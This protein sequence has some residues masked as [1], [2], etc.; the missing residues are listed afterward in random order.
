[1]P[2]MPR[3]LDPN[4]D[5]K[6]AE[7]TMRNRIAAAKSKAKKREENELM[8]ARND[9]LEECTAA[10]ARRCDSIWEQSSELE[11]TLEQMMQRIAALRAE[12][13]ALTREKAAL[14]VRAP[15]LASTAP[16]PL[17]RP[18]V[19]LLPV[20]HSIF[21]RPSSWA[22]LVQ[23]GSPPRGSVLARVAIRCERNTYTWGVDAPC[24]PVLPLNGA[25]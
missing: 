12:K 24:R 18:P 25:P 7:R 23:C 19:T 22:I 6:K 11:Q 5:P 15:E 20:G 21:R 9:R 1:M 8:Q 10:L 17:H 3:R 13:E 14:E 2:T 16:R 4:I